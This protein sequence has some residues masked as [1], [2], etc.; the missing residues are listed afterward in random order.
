MSVTGIGMRG[1]SVAIIV[2]ATL[3][4]VIIVV[5]QFVAVIDGFFSEMPP[6]P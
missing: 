4:G 5:L 3:S 2:I 6:S 1:G